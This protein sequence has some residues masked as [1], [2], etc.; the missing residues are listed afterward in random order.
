MATEKVGIREFRENL[1]TYLLESKGPLAVT[2]HGDTIGLYIPVRRRRTDAEREALREASEKMQK[3]LAELGITED[4]I[5]E[6]FKKWK[7]ENRKKS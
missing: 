6:D 7:A 4:E 5:I 2:R 1:A 3:T